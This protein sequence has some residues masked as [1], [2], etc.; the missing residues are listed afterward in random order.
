MGLISDPRM[1]FLHDVAV[2]EELMVC[3]TAT[4]KLIVKLQCACVLPLS[5]EKQYKGNVFNVYTG[6]YRNSI[7]RVKEM[8]LSATVLMKLH[9]N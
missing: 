6:R 8:T 2:T 9:G 5:T 4:Q 1:P 3:T 7:M